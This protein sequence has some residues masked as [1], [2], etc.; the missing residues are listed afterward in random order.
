MR[1]NIY[2]TQ[3]C[4]AHSNGEDCVSA[5]WLNPDGSASD[6][7][8]LYDTRNEAVFALDLWKIS[9]LPDLAPNPPTPCDTTFISAPT[10]PGS[11]GPAIAGGSIGCT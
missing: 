8:V 7:S 9:W 1:F 10:A 6:D 4:W 2:K 3:G 5:L 11:L